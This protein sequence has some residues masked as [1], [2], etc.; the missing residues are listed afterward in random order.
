MFTLQRYQIEDLETS[1][2]H[3]KIKLVTPNSPVKDMKTQC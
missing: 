2:P 1:Q 3:K